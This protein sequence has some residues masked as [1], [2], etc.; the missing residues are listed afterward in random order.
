MRINDL[1]DQ[2]ILVLGLGREGL[3]TVRFLKK[4]LP[5][6]CFSVAD[7]K[8]L[9]EMGPEVRKY[10]EGLS[11]VSLR[12]GK[13]YLE[14]LEEFDLIIKTPGISP[15][16]PAI[17][18]AIES[19]VRM[20]SATNLFC[21]EA[22]GRVVGV[23]GTKGKSTTASLISAVLRKGGLNADLIGNIGKPAL[24]FLENDSADRIYVFEMSSYMLMDFDGEVDTAVMVSFF[25]E[26]L[27]YHGDL[28]AYFQ[29][30]MNLIRRVRA[31]GAVVYNAGFGRV[32]EFVEAGVGQYGDA[33]IRLIP[34][35]GDE[36]GGYLVRRG[37][38]VVDGV[39]RLGLED[40]HLLG[41]H[42]LENMLAAWAVGRRY[43]VADEVIVEALKEF[44]GL[45]HRLEFV[46]KFQ[47]IDFY[48]D[49][50]ST[51]PE[52][53]IAA[54]NALPEGKI[55]TLI[56]GGLDRGYQFADLGRKIVT[57]GIENLI[58]F[59]E[60]GDKIAA[61]CKSPTLRLRH[62]ADMRSAVEMAYELTSPDR[63][64][65]LSCASPSYNMFVN[66]EDKGNQFKKFVREIEARICGGG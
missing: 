15:G 44:R 34:Y 43:G 63:I 65:L 51:T 10:L 52:S 38:L 26:H 17:A 11:G 18:A 53:T 33:N 6:L 41:E 3:A 30:K 56:A 21:A 60:T 9:E 47:G 61:E 7:L 42:N 8:I 19:G 13:D 28:E 45:E 58:L 2:K 31:G 48:N 62:A 25:P 49:A 37:Q 29:A 22:Q 66:F 24:E 57:A 55:S 35:S 5:E 36:D 39:P 23:S 54:I 16:A 50:I 32:R 1:K 27:N 40:V 4:R 64:C 46:G 20:S 12:L 14:G 59:P